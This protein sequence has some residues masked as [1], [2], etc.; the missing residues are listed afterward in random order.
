MISNPLHD[1]QFLLDLDKFNNKELFVKIIALDKKELP[2]EQIEGK[3]TG[4]SINID[5]S[6]ALRR[7]CN[8]SLVAKDIKLTDYYWG[9]KN[10]FKLEIG[11]RNIINSKYPDII[12]FKMG[13]YVIT[14][15]NSSKTVNNFT[16]SISGKDKMC[17]LNGDLSGALPHTTDFGIEEYYD[18]IT[19]S[20]TY[21][22]VPIKTIIREAVQNFG[23]ELAHNI[24]INDV[25]DNGL[26]L[27]EYRGNTPLYL[28]KD[29]ETG[30]YTNMSING[31]QCV[32]IADNNIKYSG[33]AGRSTEIGW[34]VVGEFP[35]LEKN[36]QKSLDEENQ[37]KGINYNYTIVNI[38][39]SL[40]LDGKD[41][42]DLTAP[43]GPDGELIYD[44]L[45][46]LEPV[47]EISLPTD[48]V[49]KYDG[50]RYNIVKIEY[51]DLLGYRETDLVFAG[52]LVANV[53]E[54][55]TSVLDKIRDMLGEFEYFY[56][57]D[58]RFVFRRKPYYVKTPWTLTEKDATDQIFEE[59]VSTFA[60]P[61]YRFNG[62]NLITNISNN[63]NL[64][65]LRND[66]STW[67]TRKTAEG[68]ELPI[69]MR[70]AIDKKPTKYFSLINQE[71][72]TSEV[73]DWR[74]LIYQMALDYRKH[75]HDDNFLYDLAEAN[76]VDGV[77]L[78]PD[79][80]TGYEQYYV[81][82]EGFWRTLYNPNPDVI[83]ESSAA[84]NLKGMREEQVYIKNYHE[85]LSY[86]GLINI[87]LEEVYI[88]QKDAEGKHYLVPFI[89]SYCKQLIF[90]D[91][92]NQP[93]TYYEVQSGNAVAKQTFFKMTGESGVYYKN[94]YDLFNGKNI[95]NFYI[96]W[97]EDAIA[98]LFKYS[99]DNP[100]LKVFQ[101]I[102]RELLHV[103]SSRENVERDVF[104]ISTNEEK[105]ILVKTEKYGELIQFIYFL[106][107]QAIKSNN[108]YIRKTNEVISFKDL[109]DERVKEAYQK[110]GTYS[111]Y[112]E[113]NDVNNFGMH[114]K[115]KPEIVLEEGKETVK[116]IKWD[117]SEPLVFD[118]KKEKI[119]YYYGYYEFVEENGWWT[120]KLTEEPDT[121]I[122]WFDFLDAE[123]SDLAKYSVPAIGSRSKSI[124]DDNV[125][126]IVYRDI[127]NVIFKTSK[128]NF[129]NLPPEERDTEPGYSWLQLP[130]NM[131]NLFVISSKGK[132][133]K[134]R[135]DELLY[136]HACCVDSINLTAIPVYY[137]EPN[138]RIE[139]QDDENN[140]SGEYI[141]NRLSYN[142]SH[143]GTMSITA[144]KAVDN[145]I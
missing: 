92:N 42:W 118:K 6:S 137:L 51:G 131:E 127:P 58:G 18:K 107:F 141:V 60:N 34:G 43:E 63:P 41:L 50:Q 33:L 79:G 143:N 8:L 24:I 74:E 54:T 75:Y 2:I 126:S 83:L 110:D 19:N 28:F 82:M 133:A 53:G 32:Y 122:F 25:E 77:Y 114:P 98:D 62:S 52:E 5:G 72:Y 87:D 65:N 26:E 142:L 76:K 7:T 130:R 144:V 125:K 37:K 100:N 111:Q 145:L 101:T 123:G 61:S 14:S 29:K 68:A 121:L 64:L 115:L 30:N 21:T 73:W 20:T 47:E 84:D 17:L 35:E 49:F 108:L 15:F 97:D 105:S 138:I 46:P 78:Y 139:V 48:V 102:D 140:I 39:S 57:L 71:W 66:Y 116:E 104:G 40:S 117:I 93:K 120:S 88:M 70:Y 134:E 109:K 9:L 11:L 56:D 69:H 96:K 136:N 67:G 12:W 59:T 90:N 135:T 129:Q 55:I 1:S 81:D 124:K 44:S 89:D 95:R 23:N 106:F 16:I 99:E 36:D 38:D 27:L 45:V 86:N 103:I 4:G 13:T 94:D 128:D 91:I 113:W 112:L 85:Q 3:A 80:H 132:T 119:D 22:S 31:D 10:K